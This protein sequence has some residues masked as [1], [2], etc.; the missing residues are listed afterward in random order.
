MGIRLR[1]SK[2]VHGNDFEVTRMAFQHC[3]ERLATDASETVNAY[4]SSHGNPPSCFPFDCK[5]RYYPRIK[6]KISSRFCSISVLVLAST[7][8]RRRGSVLDARTLNHQPP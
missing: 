4:A 7:F 2:I 5:L 3:F 8:T 1:I 6:A